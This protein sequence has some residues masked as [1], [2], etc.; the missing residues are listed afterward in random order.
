MAAGVRVLLH[1]RG[2]HHQNTLPCL[3]LGSAVGWRGRLI[4]VSI[5]SG[6]LEAQ[7]A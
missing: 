5:E 7:G 6:G 2:H 3:I 1:G 4:I